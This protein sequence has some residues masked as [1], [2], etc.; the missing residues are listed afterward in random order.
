MSSGAAWLS[1]APQTVQ[2]QFLD[3]LDEHELAALPWMFDFWA[4][5]HQLAPEGDWRTWVIMGGRGAGKTRAGSEW[6]RSMVEGDMPMD[7]GRAK[8][9]ALVGETFDQVRDV[10]IFGDSG[11]LACSPPDRR[12]KWEASRRRLVWANG[13]VAEAHSASSPEALRGPQFDAAWVDELAKWKKAE[14]AW[15]ML[16]FGLRLGERP[17]QVVTTTPRNVQVLKQ[18]L[19]ASSTV[20][21][22]APTEANRAYLASNF[23]EEVRN[24]Y[25]GTRLGRQELDGVLLDD[26]E[27]ALWKTSMLE[28]TRVSELPEF[29]RIV[30]AV[31]P[32]VSS[33]KASDACGIM[34]VGAQTKGARKDWRAV[35]IEDATIQGASPQGWAEAVVAAYER[36]GADRVV[37]EVN[38]GGDLVE[39][40]LRQVSPMTP[41]KSVRATRGKIARA[42]PIAALY[43]Q[44]RVAHYSDLGALE[45]QMCNMTTQGYVGRGSPDRVDAL[46]WALT[47]LMGGPAER[48]SV[49]TL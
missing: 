12:P 17:Q 40:L 43:E 8:R 11:I 24:R 16:Q 21:T 45:D 6:V 38:Q 5:D 33:G 47:E 26:A 1:S 42:E 22:S 10:M 14:E 4:L 39:T 28:R 30:V 48:P 20:R 31:D 18:L 49:R 27:G 15:D 46:V 41:Y 37:A 35:V 44:G 19:Q 2:D 32:A 3:S 25:G 34:V 29:D 9:V 36:H 7:P 13:A 23:L